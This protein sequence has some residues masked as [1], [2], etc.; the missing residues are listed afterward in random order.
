MMI[1]SIGFALAAVGLL[2][3]PRP[4]PVYSRLAWLS[5]ERLDHSGN[6]LPAEGTRRTIRV[7]REA[8]RRQRANVTELATAIAA[9]ADEYAAGAS[10][11]KAFTS[12][13]QV[14]VHYRGPLLHA[15]R[16]ASGGG[17]VSPALAAEP[18][19][20]CLAVACAVAARAGT[21]LA[22]VLHTVRADLV[23][24]S[25]VRRA[26]QTA[27]AGPRTSAML[28]ALLPVVGIAMG[29]GMGADP[30]RVLMH[31]T[32]GLIAATLGVLLDLG[33]V[34]W[35]FALARRAMP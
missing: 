21:P 17:D 11:T 31:T 22:A 25:E 13:G 7:W 34:L 20:S 15:A 35:S 4:S 14:A 2:A 32:P 30:L 18:S 3:L 8:R 24:D 1:D 23:A 29:A 12:A 33:G 6:S 9:I 5:R 10:T 28:L 27:L 19:L 26:V 16:L